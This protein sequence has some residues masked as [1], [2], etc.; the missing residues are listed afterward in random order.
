VDSA[1]A[2][3]ADQFDFLD[4]LRESGATNMFG[5]PAY[6]IEEYEIERDEAVRIT[7]LWMKTFDPEKPAVARVEEA[8]RSE[9]A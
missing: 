5:A 3:L 8:L 4:A 7:R 1:T 6:L 9:A 2:D